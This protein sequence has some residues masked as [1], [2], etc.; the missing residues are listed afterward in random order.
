[1]DNNREVIIIVDGNRTTLATARN[2]L[3]G[4]YD[5]LTAAS[6]EKLFMLL[7]KVTPS[8]VL[9]DLEMPGMDG[10]EVLDK[11][12][13]RENIAHIPVIFLTSK[14]D[15][16]SEIKGLNLGAVDYITKPFSPEL[17][18]KRI[19]LHIIYEKQKKKLLEHNISL[20]SENDRK[21]V[22]V[23]ELQ[24]AILKTV[25]ELVECR[26]NVTGRHIDRTQHYLSLLVD[27]LLEHG[28]YS[29][30][31]GAWDINLFIMSSQLHDVGKISIKDEILLKPGKLTHDE[32]EKMKMHTEFGVDIIRRIEENTSENAFLQYA[33]IMAGSH[34]E[35][36][37][38]TGYPKGLKGREIPLMGRLMAI[39]DVYDALTNYRPYKKAFTHMEAVEIVRKG[40]GKHFD[41]FI[42]GVFLVHENEFENK[43]IEKKIFSDSNDKLYP[44]IK[45]MNNV[46]GTRGG[47]KQGHTERI[48]LYLEIFISALLKHE[49]YCDEVS[50]WDLDLFFMSAQLHDVGNITV[51]DYILNKNH[52]LTPDEYESIKAHADFGVRIIQKIKENVE[53]ESL[54]YHAEALT[55]SHHE[56]WDG[57]G[58]PRGLKGEE[59]PLQGRIMAIVDVYEALTTD[60]PHR[61]RKTHKDAV[62]T[63][64][65]GG[66]TQFDP[67]LINVFLNC[68]SEIK[69]A[70]KQ[71]L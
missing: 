36:W 35:K 65:S 30:E 20:K 57:S 5:V 23:F 62:E 67:D 42:T 17:L 41:P 47:K 16:E 24:N 29:T 54:L 45:V 11:M 70:E 64:R 2:N 40:L 28:I 46:V 15:P 59:I 7:E 49:K 52:K 31:L 1:M 50:S 60:R 63:I 61:E 8:L 3:A 53:N 19:D 32:F 55:G 51:A 44:I 56:K 66:G 33:G 34:H 68:E 58:Y 48:L 27:F 18:I 10:Y 9:L 21:S 14:I 13:K 39:V 71:N 25:A 6:G 37:D 69:N 26:D 43:T 38:G 12:K 4:Q 22:N